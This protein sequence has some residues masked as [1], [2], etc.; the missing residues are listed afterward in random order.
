MSLKLLA[1]LLVNINQIFIF[2][3]NPIQDPYHTKDSILPHLHFSIDIPRGF[4]IIK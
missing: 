3:P 2:H 4:V 1:A